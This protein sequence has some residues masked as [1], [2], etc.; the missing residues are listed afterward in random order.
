MQVYKC[1]HFP[2]P[3][4]HVHPVMKRVVLRPEKILPEAYRFRDEWK[5][6]TPGLHPYVTV[7]CFGEPFQVVFIN[8]AFKH[9]EELE[10][11]NVARRYRFL[12]CVKELLEECAEVPEPTP[13][14]G[15][16]LKGQAPPYGE[17]FAVIM[18]ADAEIASGLYGYRLSTFY[19]LSK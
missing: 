12:P 14:G 10:I 11:R 8:P 3:I 15:L 4:G 13:K 18:E 5:R 16:L 7:K 19:P 6:E 1:R 9:I 2:Y 17:G